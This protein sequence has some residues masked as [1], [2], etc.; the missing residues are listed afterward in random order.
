MMSEVGGAFVCAIISLLVYM[1]AVQQATEAMDWVSRMCD[2]GLSFNSTNKIYVR[3]NVIKAYT[4]ICFV[5]CMLLR[6][7]ESSGMVEH[8]SPAVCRSCAGFKFTV[9][10]SI[11]GYDDDDDDEGSS[12]CL[13]LAYKSQCN[14]T[15][16]GDIA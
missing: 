11:D 9:T 6:E 7:R 12:P 16:S 4:N 10:G 5:L 15:A 8:L 13:C 1:Y 3:L 14:K 2:G